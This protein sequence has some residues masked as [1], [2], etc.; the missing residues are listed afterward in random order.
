MIAIGSRVVIDGKHEAVV[1]QVFKE[2][3]SSFLFPHYRV[4]FLCGDKN[5]AVADF[6]VQV[7]K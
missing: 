4:D 3:S 7:K 2:G 1:R 5:V 6:R